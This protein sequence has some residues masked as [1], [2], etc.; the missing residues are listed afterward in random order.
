MLK[1][2]YDTIEKERDSIL[3]EIAKQNTNYE[4]KIPHHEMQKIHKDPF[5]SQ[6]SS[7]S[8]QPYS[9]NPS[10]P[11]QNPQKSQFQNAN[12]Q[13]PEK[14]SS[15]KKSTS[16]Y[17]PYS[18]NQSKMGTNLMEKE[19]Q[20][21]KDNLKL[22]NVFISIDII[23]KFLELAKDNSEI[24]VETCGILGGKETENKFYVTCII[25]PPQKGNV[26][27]CE[28]LDEEQLFKIMTTR[29]LLSI[30][31]I[32]THPSYVTNHLG[33]FFKCH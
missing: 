30:G 28:V 16:N 13:K 19:Y 12:T 20:A 23:S 14:N 1:A 15:N 6:Y 8:S 22:R 7:S 2:Y 11:F 29:N 18:N 26:V 4:E 5:Q 9:N 24:G 27:T 10:H 32:H 33:L 3:L 21:S 25:L 17:N 31:W